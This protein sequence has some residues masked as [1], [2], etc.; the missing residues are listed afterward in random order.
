QHVREELLADD[1]PGLA[2]VTDIALKWGFAHLGRFAI[3]YKRVFGESPSAT[4]RM[5]RVRG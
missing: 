1:T 2:S 4:L 3:E 5:R